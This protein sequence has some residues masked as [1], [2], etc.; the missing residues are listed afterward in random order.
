MRDIRVAY[1]DLMGLPEE[2]KPLRRLR[3]MWE[4]NIKTN[5]Q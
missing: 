3:H 5:L 2:K 1:R 4:D